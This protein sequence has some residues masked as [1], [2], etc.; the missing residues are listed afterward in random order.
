MRPEIKSILLNYPAC[1]HIHII[2]IIMYVTPQK[3]EWH[4]I[5]ECT[6]ERG[7]KGGRTGGN[8]SWVAPDAQVLY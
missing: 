4:F 2:Y 1:M 7:N 8:K 5:G 3:F 6:E